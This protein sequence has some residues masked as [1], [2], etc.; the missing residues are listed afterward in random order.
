MKRVVIT[1]IGTVNPTG[2]GVKDSWESLMNGRSGIDKIQ[3]DHDFSDFP[4]VIAGQVKD[5]DPTNFGMKPKDVK[6]TARFIQFALAAA[7]EAVEDSG[8]DIKAEAEQVGTIIGSGIGGIDYLEV[9]TKNLYEKGVRRVS[10]FTVPM[11][12]ADMAAGLV[13]IENGAKGPNS[14]VVTACASGAHSIGDSF[15][16]IRNGRAVAMIA[17]GAE[18]AITPIGMAGFCAA[19]TLSKRNDEPQKASRPFNMD[20]DGFVMGEGSGILILEEYEHA[21]ARGANIYAEIVGYGLTGD[22]FHMTAP[23]PD[24]NGGIRA[25]KMCL[26]DAELNPE[27]ID[28]INAHGTS[29][30]LNDK[31][32]TAAIKTVFGDHA[33]KLAVS[34][35]KSMTGH[36]LGGAGAIEAVFSVKAIE[37]QIAPPT[38]NYENPD[39][40]CDLD[41][42]PN[43]AREMK[44][45]AVVSNS[46]G[47]GGHNAVL[48]FKKI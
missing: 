47:F 11:M 21:K 32:E 35:T 29:T 5:F 15:H 27:D 36:L 4:T 37:N 26:K 43:A 10:P 7:K 3:S 31:I 19:K 28:Y 2:I 20:R 13:S 22:A 23:A 1:G 17:G 6:K 14:C 9:Q 30:A 40:D 42:V 38:I 16:L 24:G 44:I 34:S 48:A 41:Y 33:Y 8:L 45:N 46:L 25:M 39:P 12:I 18:A